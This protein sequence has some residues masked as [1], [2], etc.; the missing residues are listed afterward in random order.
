MSIEM[1]HCLT[2]DELKSGKVLDDICG[3][4]KA[5]FKEYK[6]KGGELNLEDFIEEEVGVF[7]D[8]D[9]IKDYLYQQLV[10]RKVIKTA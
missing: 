3:E 8:M 4:V 10:A 5:V 7:V 1:D 2:I 6:E 9:V